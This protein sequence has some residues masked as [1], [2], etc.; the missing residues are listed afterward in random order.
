LEATVMA[1]IRAHPGVERVIPATTVSPLGL[2]MPLI[3]DDSPIETYGVTAED[4]AY[5]VELYGLELAEGHLPRPNSNEIVIPWTAARNRNVHVGDVI[6]DRDRPIYPGAPTLPS[7][8]VVSGIFARAEDPDEDVWLSFMSQEFVN[9][10]GSDWRTDLSLVVVPKAG[11]KATLDAWLESQIDEQGCS[12]R[13][14]GKQQAWMEEGMNTGLFTLSLMESIIALVAAL[15]LAG[16]NYIFV[17][18]RQAEFGVL[19]ALGFGRLQLVWRVARESLFTTGVAWLVGLLGCAAILAYLQYGLYTPSGL[20]LD[21]FNLTPWLFTLPVP[22]AVLAVSAGAVG[23]AL[24]QL[25]P[26]VIIER[27]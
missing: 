11:Q 19:N 13:T 21:F 5:L 9:S 4:M 23:W 18:Q 20:R 25:D 12:V 27:R 7:E 10:Y 8:L 16:L 22:V 15:A 1:Q 6:G 17:T 2:A 14:Y 26:V 24:S 3:R